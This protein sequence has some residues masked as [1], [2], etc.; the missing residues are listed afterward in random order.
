VVLLSTPSEPVNERAVGERPGARMQDVPE[1]LNGVVSASESGGRLAL[2]ALAAAVL[3]V[4][5]APPLSSEARRLEVYE[6][7]QFVL[8]AI[9]APALVVMAAPWRLLGLSAGAAFDAD[10]EGVA[11]VDRPRMGDRMAAGRRRHPEPVRSLAFLLLEL[12][13]VVAWRSPAAVDAVARHGWLSL[14]EAATLMGAGIGLW[15]EL[16]ESPPFM[17]RL[18]R[19]RR[20][21]AGAV[22]MWTVWVTAYLLGLSHASVY[23][24]FHHVAGRSL[25]VAADQALT[26]WVLWFTSLCA[27]LPVIFTNLIVWL[28]SGEDPDDALRRLVRNGRR[29]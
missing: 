24:A 15:L 11:V 22:A 25:S 4:A 10:T 8:L 12:A 17:P 23:E 9:A 20:I 21:M 13:A 1:R 27:F 6:A 7:L 29:H 14:V 3:V 28:R 19:P 26:T 5:L 18:A 16:V 2:A